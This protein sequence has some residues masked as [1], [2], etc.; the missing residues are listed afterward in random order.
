LFGDNVHIKEEYVNMKYRHPYYYLLL[1]LCYGLSAQVQADFRASKRGLS[2][3]FKSTDISLKAGG[4]LNVDTLI[5][6][7]SFFGDDIE[8]RRLR[9]NI[10]AQFGDHWRA[11]VDR[12]FSPN[13]S[14]W[15]NVW[16][17]YRGKNN[18]RIKAGQFITPFSLEEQMAAGN[19]TFMSRAMP[20]AL[21]PRFRLGIAATKYSDHWTATLGTFANSIDNGFV[22]SVD[23]GL[24]LDDGIS[25][26]AR[27]T[28][29]PIRRRQ[30]VVHLG[31]AVEHR[32]LDNG[33][34]TQVHSRQEITTDRRSFLNTGHIQD[35]QSYTAI[36]LET[37]YIQGPL[38]LQAQYI[39]KVTEVDE[40]RDTKA[41]GYY[42][43]ASYLIGNAERRYSRT[44]GIV[45]DVRPKSK[46]GA[47]ELAV[48]LSTLDLENN[49]I[50]GGEGTNLT[51]GASWYANR[52]LRFSVNGIIAK[53]SPDRFGN[54][55]TNTAVQTRL[56][57]K[58]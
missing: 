29:T 50:S 5:S 44:S 53:V 52:N 12:D 58:F 3:D 1:I 45:R 51:L 57:I 25:F 37:A 23:N 41:F 16:I 19:L 8:I 54:K 9:A 28:Y 43:Q 47:L 11:K 30:H 6:N 32:R 38:L 46:Y 24:A 26:V 31:A 48:R 42:A 18:L 21:A 36:N 20:S 56:Q 55:S 10:T 34:S 4:I 33:A 13:Y 15:R 39:T 27:G 49:V 14:G 7:E 22:N 35:A 17:Q 40:S 2:Y